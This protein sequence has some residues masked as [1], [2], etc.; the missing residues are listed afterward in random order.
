MVNF[1]AAK[2]AGARAKKRAGADANAARFGRTKAER[3]AAADA[4]AR[5]EKHL[6][7]HRLDTG[8]EEE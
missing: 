3:G 1:K 4:G 6:D 2:K 7:D 5:A 8:R